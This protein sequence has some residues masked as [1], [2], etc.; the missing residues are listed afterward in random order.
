MNVKAVNQDTNVQYLAHENKWNCIGI[1]DMFDDGERLWFTSIEYNALFKMSKRTFCVE[2]VG[3]F[4]DEET[5]GN[6]LYT[7]I[8]EHNGKLFFTPCTAHEIGIYD[9]RNEYFEKKS[10]GISR[11]DNDLQKIKYAKKFV[12]GFIYNNALILIPCCYDRIIIYDIISGRVSSKTDMFEYFY[13]KYHDWTTSPDKEFYLCWFAKRLNNSEIVFNL[14]CN[15]NILIFYNFQTGEFRE[16]EICSKNDTFLLIECD[17]GHIFLYEAGTDKLI[18]WEMESNKYSECHIFAQLSEFRPCS[19]G[20]AF[21]NMAVLGDFIYLIPSNANVAVKVNIIT[22]EA[23]VSDELSRECLISY[24]GLAYLNLSKIFDNSLYLYGNRSKKLI[25]YGKDG[26]LQ[27]IRI[28]VRGDIEN[29]MAEQFLADLIRNNHC[30]FS[31]EHIP[32]TRFI[33]ALVSIET[34][35][36]EYRVSDGG[37]AGGDCASNIYYLIPKGTP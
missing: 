36:C 15:R 25:V 18:K 6:R 35:K 11:D 19:S 4:P 32:L 31:E 3:S 34:E 10:I 30:W 2:Y 12:S 23:F 7:S 28:K 8:N 33:N 14:Y 26:S 24:K 1:F 20:Y 9:M 16:Q 21:L 29:I 37:T 13:D 27:R 22:L 17:G 5:Y